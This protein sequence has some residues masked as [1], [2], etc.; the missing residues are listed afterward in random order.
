MPKPA[1][2]PSHVASALR[3][4]LA[5]PEPKILKIIGEESKRKGTATLSSS[6]I[7]RVIKAARAKK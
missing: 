7:E 6:Q 4:R 3:V 5:S 2:K 1:K